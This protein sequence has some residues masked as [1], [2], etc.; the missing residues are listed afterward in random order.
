MAGA[1]YTLDQHVEDLRRITAE[2]QVA[3][4]IMARQGSAARSGALQ[5]GS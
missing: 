1:T 2:T 3:R 4:V 5:C